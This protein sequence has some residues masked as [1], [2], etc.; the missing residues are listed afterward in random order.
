MTLNALS[1]L[2]AAWV[3]AACIALPVHAGPGAHGPNGEHLDGPAATAGAADASPRME[4]KSE[5]FELVATLGRGELSILI[6]RFETNEPVL[7]AKVEVESGPAKA[8][9]RFHADHGDY[10]VDD[11]AFLKRLEQPG[12]HSVV[13]TVIAA[14]DSDLLEGTLRVTTESLQAAH[15][16][17]HADDADHGA[18]PAWSRWVEAGAVG[19]AAVV[20][21]AVAGWWWRRRTHGIVGKEAV[22]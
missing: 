8:T 1:T 17:A 18:R 3:L 2:R 7:D 14:K 12:E 5:Q 16:H 13:V 19:L 10:A 9:A 4:T 6:D 21:L 20:A 15:G 22:R 11:P